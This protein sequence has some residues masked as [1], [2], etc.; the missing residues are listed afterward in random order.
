MMTMRCPGAVGVLQAAWTWLSGMGTGLT[1][2]VPVVISAA[3]AA[4]SVTMALVGTEPW[5]LPRMSMRAA[6]SQAERSSMLG[7]AIARRSE[8]R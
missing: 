2:N 4:S 3:R 8:A 5:P 6:R 1:A 7:P